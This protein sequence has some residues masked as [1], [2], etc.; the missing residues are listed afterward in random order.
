[1]GHPHWHGLAFR[2]TMTAVPVLMLAVAGGRERMRPPSM[3]V[4]THRT[5]PKKCPPFGAGRMS[6]ANT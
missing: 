5:A 2:A 6:I 4:A 3:H 1:M